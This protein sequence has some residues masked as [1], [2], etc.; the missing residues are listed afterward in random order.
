MDCFHIEP[1]LKDALSDPI[2]QAMMA[3]D[4]VDRQALELSLRKAAEGVKRP[5]G[6]RQLQDCFF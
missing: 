2:I 1:S 3:A 6:V 4:G 5:V